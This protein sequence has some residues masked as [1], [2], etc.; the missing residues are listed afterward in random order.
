VGAIVDRSGGEAAFGVPFR[1]LVRLEV[2]QYPQEACPLC[3]EGLPL[4]EV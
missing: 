4:E 1:A 2:P 3:R